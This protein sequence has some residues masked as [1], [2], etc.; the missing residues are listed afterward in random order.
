[1]S[2][3]HFYIEITPQ[4]FVRHERIEPTRVLSRLFFADWEDPVFD[5]PRKIKP[6]P[7]PK[8][9]LNTENAGE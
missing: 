6:K 8:M 5:G 7:Q 9:I 4:G 3:N 1:M 2:M